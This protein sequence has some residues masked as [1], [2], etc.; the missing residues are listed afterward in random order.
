MSTKGKESWP[1]IRER[2]APKGKSV[3][4][5]VDL[6]SIG[7]KREHFKTMAAA[8]TRAG[9]ARVDRENNLTEA[10]EL[11]LKKRVEALDALEIL[12][13]S[14]VSL[15]DAAVHYRDTVLAFKDAPTVSVIVKK[16]LAAAR[17]NGR[18]RATL[19][20]LQHRLTRISERFGSR[21]LSE[22]PFADLESWLNEIGGEA[23]TRINYATKLSQV[24]NYA[25]KNGWAN[26]NPT[27]RFAR[28][29][30]EDK[31]PGVL[32]VEQAERLLTHA[33][34][35]GLLPY[36]V[37]GLFAGLRT[38]E[39]RRLEW[40]AVRLSEKSVIVGAAVAK[41]RSRRV[42]EI[43][44][45]LAAWLESCHRKTGMV[46]PADDFRDRFDSFRKAA[47]LTT[48]PHNAL[49]HTF[50]TFH[51]AAYGDPIKTAYIMGHR[52]PELIHNHYKALVTKADAL[53]FWALR[54]SKQKRAKIIP[55]HATG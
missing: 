13:G 8:E 48:W 22:I 47:K 50:A 54:P 30:V 23:R 35:F 11:D 21:Q 2:K 53:K 14:G 7:G 16:M 10:R 49:R 33:S 27:T 52:S 19:K 29:A 1:T 3:Y 26:A 51:L 55:I 31:E 36:T 12:Q 18:R 5:V 40:S 20:D 6:R 42:V 25:I 38:A 46:T 45:T 43:N 9:Q 44:E 28:P 39:L 41:K 4:Y 37:L 24:F 34:D 32:T 15:K 17:S